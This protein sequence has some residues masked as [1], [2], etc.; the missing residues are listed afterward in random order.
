M[1]FFLRPAVSIITNCWSSRT[2]AVSI[3]SRV[4]PSMFET[5][6]RSSFKIALYK[7]DLP[8]LGLP[9]KEKWITSSFSLF[10]TL[11]NNSKILSNKSPPP[12]PWVVETTMIFESVPSVEVGDCIC[13][14]N[15]HLIFEFL[16]YEGFKF[17]IFNYFDIIL[18]TI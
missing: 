8:T 18:W 3:A 7:D 11:G 13:F 14:E 2:N 15:K 16:K 17:V 5:I 12:I 4:V 6:T 9:I 1:P 10:S